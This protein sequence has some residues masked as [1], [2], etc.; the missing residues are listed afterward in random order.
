MHFMFLDTT[1]NG[2]FFNLNFYLSIILEDCWDSTYGEKHTSFY[3]YFIPGCMLTSLTY[4]LA[5]TIFKNL[6]SD[7]DIGDPNKFFTVQI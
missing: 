5:I 3:S 6:A 7:T 1:I 2:I 4:F